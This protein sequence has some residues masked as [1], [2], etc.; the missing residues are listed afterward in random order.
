LA[1]REELLVLS[2]SDTRAN[3]VPTSSSGATLD[4]GG[5]DVLSTPSSEGHIETVVEDEDPSIRNAERALR[6]LPTSLVDRSLLQTQEMENRNQCLILTFGDYA[7]GIWHSAL[8]YLFRYH[9]L[10]TLKAF[11][12]LMVFI[13]QIELDQR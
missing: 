6:L 8:T 4:A 1:S 10:N 11:C 9:L 12:L 7:K 3:E 13:F 5:R 2:S